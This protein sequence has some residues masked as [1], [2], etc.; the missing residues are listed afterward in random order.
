MHHHLRVLHPGD[1]RRFGHRLDRPHLVV[2]RH[3]RD[4]G[5]SRAD[6]FL[7]RPQVHHAIAVHR[8]VRRLEAFALQ[9]F[10]RVQDGVVLDPRGHDVVAPPAFALGIGRAPDRGVVRLGPA[11]GEHNLPGLCPQQVG[12]EF[13]RGIERAPRLLAF[14]VDARGVAPVGCQD[15]HHCR[16]HPG[17]RPRRRRVVEVDPCHAASV[18]RQNPPFHL[19]H[20][21]VAPGCYTGPRQFL[22]GVGTGPLLFLEL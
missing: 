3:D 20:G 13:A 15:R 14:Q 17:I 8:Q 6:R 7:Q 2:R 12:D 5:G 4:H 16:D 21:P 1:A 10:D 22:T 11:A 18:T 19:P 9:L